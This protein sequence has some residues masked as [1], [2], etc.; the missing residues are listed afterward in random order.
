MASEPMVGLISGALVWQAWICPE[1]PTGGLAVGVWRRILM[2]G[3]VQPF[4]E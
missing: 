2:L 1:R 3:A 4:R